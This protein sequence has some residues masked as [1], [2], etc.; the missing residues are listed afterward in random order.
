MSTPPLFPDLDSDPPT[1]RPPV[2]L[3]P[4]P[5]PRLR[6]P[7][8]QQMLMRPCS[9]DELI[10]DEHD[11]RLVWQLVQ[12]WDL[13]RF[14]D[15]IRARGE[16]PGRAAT[17]P[18]LLVAL[19][20]YAATQGVAGGRELARL[21]E[22]SD[23]YRWLC[24]TVPVNYHMLN[25]FRVDHEAAL[26]DLLTQ[27]LAVLIHGGL[28]TIS[29]IAQDGTRVRAGAGAN[30]FKRRATIER[31][32]QQAQA[33]LEIIQRQA[34]R[35]EDATERRCASQARAAQRKI[36]RM[37]RALGELT[38]LEE[39]KA[40]QKAKPT[41]DKPPRASITDPEARFMRMS[42]GG[43]RPAFNVQLAVDTQSRAIVGVE[44]TNAGSDAGLAEPMRE[45][46]QERTDEAV[47][48]QLLDGGF[49][50]L[51]DLDRAAAAEPPVTI[52]MPVP[53]PRKAGTDPHQPKATDSA[54][55]GQ[56]RERMGTA[57]AKAIYKQRA[58]TIETGNAELKMNRGLDPFRVRGLP[59]ARCVTLWC[60]LA[61]N[62]MHFGWQMMSL[63]G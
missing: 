2:D 28:V 16:T 25:D 4:I 46:I 24:G 10:A 60:V 14:L 35:A 58:A 9:I 34:E 3:G 22:S 44:V 1:E 13:A 47:Q 17:D 5:P 63:Q 36:D 11:A 50:K 59:K 37:K 48:A 26:K 51:E 38:K 57:Q 61:Y 7:N 43:N 12:T 15:T 41:R 31:A 6:R 53:K 21:C 27:M 18:A 8:R 32:L 20:L 23:P 33:H 56:W 52:Y 19:W 30:S 39:A 62:I 54:A 55:V 40:Q 29:R 45:Q 49:V 42:D